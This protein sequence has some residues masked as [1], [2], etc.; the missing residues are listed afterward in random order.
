MAIDAITAHLAQQSGIQKLP[1]PKLTLFVQR[2][3]L[4]AAT[5]ASLCTMIDAER[6]PSTISDHLRP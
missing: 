2:G 5:C 4:D 6:R 3:F 1:S